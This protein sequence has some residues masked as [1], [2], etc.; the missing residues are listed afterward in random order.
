[1]SLPLELESLLLP[2]ENPEELARLNSAWT[3]E[4]AGE[5]HL[6][7]TLRNDVVQTDWVRQRAERVFRQ[8]QLDVYWTGLPME[9]W[10]AFTLKHF[11][12][13]KKHA[14]SAKREFR[15]ALRFLQKFLPTGAK[16]QKKA[17]ED[18]KPVLNLNPDLT[19]QL[20]FEQLVYLEKNADGEWSHW[21]DPPSSRFLEP[22]FQ[23]WFR[24]VK[25]EF[26]CKESEELPQ[27]YAW[28]NVHGRERY[29]NAK[30]T[31]I[32]YELETFQRIVAEEAQTGQLA[33]GPRVNYTRYED[34]EPIEILEP[35][36]GKK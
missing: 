3:T 4:F 13:F 17:E 15:Q 22:Q 36:E 2:N 19:G 14:H 1:M 32:H 21:Y 31:F 30:N 35:Q 8:L 10:R 28:V 7:S 16:A 20:T 33:D 18:A 9:F 5:S 27:K 23:P 12:F 11:Q 25:R 26:L 34:L 24:D 6:L 29:A